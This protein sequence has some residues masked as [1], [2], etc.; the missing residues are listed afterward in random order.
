MARQ[1]LCNSAPCRTSYM[2]RARPPLPEGKPAAIG[3]E[4]HVKMLHDGVAPS[5]S[6][7]HGARGDR[8]WGI[9]KWVIGED[10]GFDARI[11]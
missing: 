5:D 6:D 8:E 7:P 2:P 11:P 3:T 10:R 4:R 9:R 1:T